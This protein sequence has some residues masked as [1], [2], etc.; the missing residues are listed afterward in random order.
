VGE[1]GAGMS[2]RDDEHCIALWESV[3]LCV[4]GGMMRTGDLLAAVSTWPRY[5]RPTRRVYLLRAL[6][7]AEELGLLTSGVEPD[8]SYAW[9]ATIAGR[10][11]I[12]AEVGP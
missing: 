10:A 5:P 7:E 2:T 9:E 3:R 4:D 12:A 11:E 1:P 6:H 8:G